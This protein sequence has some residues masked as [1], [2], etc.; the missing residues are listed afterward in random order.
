M[1]ISSFG[2]YK[3][4]LH[5]EIMH[6]TANWLGE[7]NMQANPTKQKVVDAATGLFFQKG[8]DGTSVRDI[9]EAASVNVSL[10]SY[11]F[12]GKQGLLE[13]AVTSYYETYL[14]SLETILRENESMDPIERLKEL[15]YAIIDYKTTH[16]QLTSFIHRELSL[17]S[18]FVREM[19]FT[20]LA[21]EN[22]FLG[23]L[24]F[25]NL[26]EKTRRKDFLYM[27]L[28]GM[29]MSPFILKNEW[30]N[31]MLDNESKQLF[32]RNYSEVIAAWLDYLLAK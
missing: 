20:Y 3:I 21:K 7:M 1:Q 32:T 31:Q 18:T 9:A 17:D 6:L 2:N 27:Q 13:Y 4:D 16:F 8:F 22:H 25:T 10:I 24:F 23:E 12:K 14:E 30:N 11:Y 29:I 19:T 26:Q 28:K 15:I 5:M